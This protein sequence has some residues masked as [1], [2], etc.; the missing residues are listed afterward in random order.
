[1]NRLRDLREDKDLRQSQLATMLGISQTTYSRYETEELN[2]PVD[3]LIKLAKYYNTSIDY[4]VGFTDKK[5]PYNRINK[6]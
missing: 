3:T 4:L 2:I 6:Q 5:A 1:M